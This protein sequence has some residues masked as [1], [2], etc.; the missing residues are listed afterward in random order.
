MCVTFGEFHFISGALAGVVVTIIA[1][2]YMGGEE[3]R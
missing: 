1:L 3:V 2:W